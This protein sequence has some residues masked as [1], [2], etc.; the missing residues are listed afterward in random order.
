MIGDIPMKN[1]VKSLIFIRNLTCFLHEGRLRSYAVE[2]VGFVQPFS[3]D[4]LEIRPKPTRLTP[5]FSLR[6]KMAYR[7]PDKILKNTIF[8]RG[9]K[10]SL[11]LTSAAKHLC[12]LKPHLKQTSRQMSTPN[13]VSTLK[14]M[15]KN[16]RLT[17][18]R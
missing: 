5:F 17:V 1:P 7:H 13:Q 16:A 4:C 3:S 14:K 8:L 9:I 15:N 11:L 18:K 12:D 6:I 10:V 2:W